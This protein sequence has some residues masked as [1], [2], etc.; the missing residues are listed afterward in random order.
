M[1]SFQYYASSD[2]MRFFLTSLV[3]NFASISFNLTEC[4]LDESLFIGDKYIV[5]AQDFYSSNMGSFSGE[6]NLSSL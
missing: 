3:F 5:G 2:S 1:F 4:E 6:I